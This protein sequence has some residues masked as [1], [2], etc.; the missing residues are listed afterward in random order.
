MIRLNRRT[1]LARTCQA[2]GVILAV[3][4]TPD[5]RVVPDICRALST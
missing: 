4:C 1:G 2:T 5:W 3:R